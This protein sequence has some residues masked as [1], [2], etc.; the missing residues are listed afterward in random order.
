MIVGI[1][2]SG[3]GGLYYIVLALSMPVCELARTIRGRG[4]RQRWGKV[5]LQVGHAVGI[6]LALAGS[7]WLALVAIGRAVSRQGA[8]STWQWLTALSILTLLVVVL[9]PSLLAVGLVVR[10]RFQAAG[11]PTSGSA[12]NQGDP[13]FGLP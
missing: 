1:P 3:I 9:L 2:G 8:G 10:K 4:D 11:K 5:G 12:A 7:G 6:L 13:E